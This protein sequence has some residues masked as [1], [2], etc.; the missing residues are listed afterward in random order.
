MKPIAAS[1]LPC[2][3]NG[4]AYEEEFH[5][6]EQKYAKP[7]LGAAACNKIKL[8]KRLNAVTVDKHNIL[9]ECQEVSE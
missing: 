9:S 6:I 3:V 8:A 1:I 4:V 5:L 7:I 2:N